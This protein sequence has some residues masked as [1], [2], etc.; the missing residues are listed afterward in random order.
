MFKC[1]ADGDQGFF[2]IS[3]IDNEFIFSINNYE[4]MNRLCSEHE[5]ALVLGLFCWSNYSQGFV[6]EVVAKEDT[7]REHQI[8]V[9]AFCPY[10][11]A[12][13]SQISPQLLEN[14]MT[15]TNEPLMYLFEG[16]LMKKYRFG[17]ADVDDVIKWI[18][19]A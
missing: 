9:G 14:V 2:G 12:Q 17:P 13:I 3:F 6:A 10:C 4:D 5:R 11:Q 1:I 16:G 18:L 7:F 15:A 19:T 8:A